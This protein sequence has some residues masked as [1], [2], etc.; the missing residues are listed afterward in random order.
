MWGP[1]NGL[2]VFWPILLVALA[3]VL[4]GNAMRSCFFTELDSGVFLAMKKL[5]LFILCMLTF[6]LYHSNSGH[7]MDADVYHEISYSIIMEGHLNTLPLQ[8]SKEVSWQVTP[9]GHVPIHQNAGGIIFFLPATAFSLFSIKLAS[10][11]PSLPARLHEITH[12]ENLWIGCIAYLLTLFFCFFTYRV[13]RLYFSAVAAIA[14]LVFCFFGGPLLVYLTGFPYQ[15]HLPAA[16]LAALLLYAY[17]YCDLSKRSSWFLLGAILGLG[18]FVRAEFIAWGLLVAYGICAQPTPDWCRWRSYLERTVLAA[19]GGMAFIVPG[20]MIRQI[21]F[22][23]QGNT[24]G[25]QFD[26]EIFRIGYLMLFGTRNALFTFWPILFIAISGYCARFRQN[27]QISHILFAVLVVE[28]LICG[29]TIFWS[30]ELGASFGQRRFLVVLPVFVFFLARLFEL[31]RHRFF[32]LSSLCVACVSWAVGM[33]SLYGTEWKL[34]DSRTGFLMPNDFAHLFSAMSSYSSSIFNRVLSILFVPKHWD[35]FWLAPTVAFAGFAAYL[36]LR[37]MCRQRFL[38]LLVLLC[39]LSISIITFLSGAGK[40]GERAYRSIA[41]ANPGA[42]FLIRNF[43]VDNEIIGSMV[44]CVA[45]FRE[46][47]QNDVAEHFSA[48]ALQ[49]LVHEAPDRKQDFLQMLDALAMRQSLGWYR[50]VPEQDHMALLDWYKA[51]MLAGRT[52]QLPTETI[53]GYVY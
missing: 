3:A 45:F 20:V 16:F 35:V 50:L 43:E 34:P 47:Q 33:Y 51:A 46:R 17:H 23:A 28:C 27:Q 12:H 38:L 10:L 7:G 37:P 5:V 21:M 26:A 44:D 30:G 40:R 11:F 31:Y 19:C 4:T 41:S 8:L 24:Y 2:F 9:T 15:M 1:R 13:L 48:K 52:R 29:S 6:V 14:S 22:G 36:A 25:I 18:V 53:K 32:W 49:F 39:L 42:T